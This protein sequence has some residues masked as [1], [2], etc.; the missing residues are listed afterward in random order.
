[1][2]AKGKIRG[3]GVKLAAYLLTGE[4]GERAEFLDMRGFPFARDLKDGFRQEEELAEG[5]RATKPFFHAHFRSPEGEGKKLTR[6]Q[7]LEIADGC[8]TALGRAMTQQ[9]RGASLHID[10]KTGDVHLHLA[11]SLVAQHDDGR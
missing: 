11:Y 10:A 2:I 7:W 5:T 4:A 8:D 6:A 3:E 9:P 1:M